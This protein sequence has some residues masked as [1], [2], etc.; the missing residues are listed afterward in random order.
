MKDEPDSKGNGY[1]PVHRSTLL[2]YLIFFLFFFNILTLH[3]IKM[4]FKTLIKTTNGSQNVTSTLFLYTMYQKFV[5]NTL[6]FIFYL[7]Q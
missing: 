2:N 4:C 5:F 1:R 6:P 7:Q 3:P